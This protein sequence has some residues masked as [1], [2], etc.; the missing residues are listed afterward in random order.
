VDVWALLLDLAD[1]RGMPWS[2]LPDRTRWVP[3]AFLPPPDDP[4]RF[5]INLEECLQRCLVQAALYQLVLNRGVGEYALPDG[6][7]L[8]WG[9]SR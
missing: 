2:D 3:L 9:A 4:G 7:S 5:F 1:L 8:I 6:A